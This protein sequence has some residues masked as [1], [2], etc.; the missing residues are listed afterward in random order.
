MG[1]SRHSSVS[2]SINE[3]EEKKSKTTHGKESGQSHSNNVASLPSSDHTMTSGLGHELTAEKYT[4]K[5]G[6][7]STIEG[8]SVEGV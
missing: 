2:G 4:N 3:G 5:K 8:R 6:T 7:A 1:L